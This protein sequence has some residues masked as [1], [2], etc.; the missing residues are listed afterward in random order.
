MKRHLWKISALIAILIYPL[1]QYAVVPQ[2]PERFVD[3]VSQLGAL[4]C[5]IFF[6]GAAILI[7]EVE[8]E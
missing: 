5:L 2:V 7:Y 4:L 3:Y 6:I 1:I 8:D